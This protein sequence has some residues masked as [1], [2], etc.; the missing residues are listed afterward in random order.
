LP[1]FQADPARYH[2]V[3]QNRAVI[4]YSAAQIPCQGQADGTQ[5]RPIPSGPARTLVATK[6]RS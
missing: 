1:A 2:R 5:L 4:I 3:Y 6:L